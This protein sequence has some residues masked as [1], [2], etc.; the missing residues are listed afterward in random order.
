MRIIDLYWGPL[1]EGNYQMVLRDPIAINVR[2]VKVPYGGD[3]YRGMAYYNGK[4]V[5]DMTRISL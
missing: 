2:Y 1:I 3:Y 4:G 5:V